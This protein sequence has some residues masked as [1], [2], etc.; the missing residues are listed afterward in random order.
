MPDRACAG[1]AEHRSK[2]A[3][4]RKRGCDHH[5]IHHAWRALATLLRAKLIRTAIRAGT[6]R[7]LNLQHRRSCLQTLAKLAGHRNR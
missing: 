2:S 7:A 3:P 4:A 6:A 5:G 1:C